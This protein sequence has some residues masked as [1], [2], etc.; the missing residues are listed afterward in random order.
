M[1]DK[2]ISFFCFPKDQQK[3]KIWVHYCKRQYFSPSKHSKIC[4]KHF[5][6][7]Q[8]S[9]KPA[10]LT[11]VPPPFWIVLWVDSFHSMWK[12]FKHDSKYWYTR[13][14]GSLTKHS[15][16]FK[17]GQREWS[18]RYNRPKRLHFLPKRHHFFCKNGTFNKNNIYSNDD[19][20]CD[21]LLLKICLVN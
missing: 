21:V 7:R 19:I 1:I 13:G 3:L 10:R 9:R 11:Y 18:P 2:S 14:S 4:S 6:E 12:F 17:L 8:Y 16:T 5:T 20:M 15:S